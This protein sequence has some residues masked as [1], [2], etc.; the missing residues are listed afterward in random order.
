MSK[1][2]I[3]TWLV[4]GFVVWS[5][6]C[7]MTGQQRSFAA[8]LGGDVAC[9]SL[10]AMCIAG[11]GGEACNHTELICGGIDS[12]I[13]IATMPNDETGE[14][15]LLHCR[16]YAAE[17]VEDPHPVWIDD[18]T[19]AVCFDTAAELVESMLEDGGTP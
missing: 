17:D 6:S 5:L 1:R 4:L 2:N 11:Q 13:S 9:G 8:K 15:Y 16:A 3:A 12:V 14:S 10:K 18:E 7:A 19:V